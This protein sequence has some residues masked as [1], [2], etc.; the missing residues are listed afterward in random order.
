[1][2]YVIENDMMIDSLLEVFENIYSNIMEKKIE[3]YQSN[4]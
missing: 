4:N 1:M 2:G 3:V